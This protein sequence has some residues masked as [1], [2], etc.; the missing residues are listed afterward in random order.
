MYS[1]YKEN[2]KNKNIKT[3]N[4]TKQYNYIHSQ[5]YQ[6][7][8]DV[9]RQKSELK[10]THFLIENK[11]LTN[12]IQLLVNNKWGCIELNPKHNAPM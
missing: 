6:N 8:Y 4:G 3:G 5:K 10:Q 11:Y 7:P 12:I 9:L 2:Q 1:F